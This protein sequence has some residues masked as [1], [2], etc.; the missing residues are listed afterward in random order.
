MVRS[1]KASSRCD[2]H[3]GESM[4]PSTASCS[5]TSS[6][7]LAKWLYRAQNPGD[8]VGALDAQAN[9]RLIYQPIS[10]RRPWLPSWS[11]W[12]Y[13]TNQEI[14]KQVDI[15]GH[16][17]LQSVTS[18]HSNDEEIKEL[19]KQAIIEKH[20]Q[21]P[22]DIEWA[23][24]GIDGVLHRSSSSRDG[25]F[26][27]RPK[28][29]SSVTSRTTKADVLV[30]TKRSTYLSLAQF[31]WL[32]L[33]GP[34]NSVTGSRRRC[35]SNRHDRPRLGTCYEEKPM[36]ATNRGGHFGHASNHRSWARWSCNR[37]ARQRNK[38]PWR[39]VRPWQCHVLKA[40]LATFTKVSQSSY[41]MFWGWWA[42]PLLPPTK[43]MMNVGNPEIVLILRANSKRRCWPCSSRVHQQQDDR[44]SPESTA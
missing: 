29:L 36:I 23:K 42:A 18:S 24:D 14:G 44:Y 28:S 34:Q 35:T 2:V 40:K 20:Y 41:Q 6:W 5:L 4:W 32:T 17:L 43:V 19:A 37:W 38:Q 30:G 15:I 3:T 33:P 21:R 11:R 7:V 1:D 27:K 12:S 26:S 16:R 10:W 31:V 8:G 13:S 22:M 9:V 25:M 39:P